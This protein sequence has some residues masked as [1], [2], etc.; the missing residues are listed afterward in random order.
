MSISAIL[1]GG[2]PA[3]AAEDS[4]RGTIYTKQLQFKL[5]CNDKQQ[6][7][8]T[9]FEMYNAYNKL[10]DLEWITKCTLTLLYAANSIKKHGELCQNIFPRI[11]HKLILTP[12]II[13]DK[14]ILQD[15]GDF[16]YVTNA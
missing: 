6:V 9:W 5:T 7:Y 11:E 1:P 14:L 12:N 10:H 15:V 2:V 4:Q 16:L 13:I 3:L 8:L